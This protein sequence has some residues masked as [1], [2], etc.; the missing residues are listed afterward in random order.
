MFFLFCFCFFKDDEVSPRGKEPAKVG[1]AAGTGVGQTALEHPAEKPSTA[2]S[3]KA[4]SSEL[5]GTGPLKGHFPLSLI[6]P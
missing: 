3:Y 1:Q 6:C 2:P 5:M 4:S